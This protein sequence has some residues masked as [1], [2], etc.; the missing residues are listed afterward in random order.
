MALG[1]TQPLRELATR[2]LSWV[3]KRCRFTTS[4]PSLSQFSRKCSILDVSQTS[5]PLMSVTRITLY[6]FWF[7]VLVA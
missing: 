2:H 7:T 6:I 5:R 4:P 1:L 3:V